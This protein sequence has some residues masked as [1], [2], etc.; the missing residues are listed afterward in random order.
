M[1][2][3]FFLI[4][5]Y[6]MIPMQQYIIHYLFLLLTTYLT[7]LVPFN[8][9]CQVITLPNRKTITFP[10]FNQGLIRGG[11]SKAAYIEHLGN[12]NRDNLQAKQKQ[13][14]CELLRNIYNDVISAIKA[15]ASSKDPKTLHIPRIVHQI[16]LGSPVPNQYKEWMETWMNWKGWEY[17]LWTDKEVKQLR[18]FNQEIYDK[19]T[20]YGQKADI[21]RM[22]LLYLIGGLYIDT[23]FECLNPDFFELLHNNVDF[24][25]GVEPLEH[26]CLRINNAIIGCSPGHPLMEKMI[27]GLPEHFEATKKKWALVSTG[28]VFM[29]KVVYAYLEQN[30]PEINVFLPCSL[31][32]PFNSSEVDRS[33]SPESLIPMKESVAVHYWS[34]SWVK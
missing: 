24:Y 18:L 17:K 13:R 28:P 27:Q 19:V 12:K 21:L 9:D 15:N 22:E 23:D 31:V 33:F 7:L 16:W 20:N 6:A 34:K 30:H 26:A 10:N 2:S 11:R 3:P 25:A 8:S 4:K 32:Y 29:T 5:F 1:L 14:Q